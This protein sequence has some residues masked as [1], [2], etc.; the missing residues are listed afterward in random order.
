MVL[1]ELLEAAMFAQIGAAVAHPRDRSV[2]R[3]DQHTD[4][5]RAH[6]AR[7]LMGGLV[8]DN[9]AVGVL[10]R[11]LQQ[12]AQLINSGASPDSAANAIP[13][14]ADVNRPRPLSGLGA[15]HPVGR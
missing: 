7:L 3:R 4:G 11:L 10:E 13:N 6:A 8:V 5:R 9:S 15:A 14:R 12:P 1:R 2:R